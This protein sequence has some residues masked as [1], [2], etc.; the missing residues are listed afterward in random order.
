MSLSKSTKIPDDDT[1]WVIDRI[2]AFPENRNM[3]QK[4][5]KKNT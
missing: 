1:S 4:K 5:L 3:L 2:I